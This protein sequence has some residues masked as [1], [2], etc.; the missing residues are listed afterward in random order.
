MFPVC[1]GQRVGACVDGAMRW[2]FCVPLGL[3]LLAGCASR[4]H[5]FVLSSSAVFLSI[6]PHSSQFVLFPLKTHP[7]SFLCTPELLPF[8]L[9]SCFQELGHAAALVAIV[10]T[11]E[12][13]GDGSCS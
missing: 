7:F 6:V 10:V 12:A 11:D 5:Q 9:A 3:L 13:D 1:L 8:S 4:S 2:G